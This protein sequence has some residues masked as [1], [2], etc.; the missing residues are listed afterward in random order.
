MYFVRS[1]PGTASRRVDAFSCST[2]WRS[3]MLTGAT[4][5]FR[6]VANS[7]W[8]SGSM[9][10]SLKTSFWI[11]GSTYGA[12]F[13]FS[14]VKSAIVSASKS[15]ST[16]HSSGSATEALLSRTSW[17]VHLPLAEGCDSPPQA[18]TS[19]ARRNAVR[20]ARRTRRFGG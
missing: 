9:A 20:I 11:S 5:T 10:K 2:H 1:E 12:N 13:S 19:V 8:M 4:M 17:R 18:L 16:F 15:W 14:F 6:F 7:S 3:G